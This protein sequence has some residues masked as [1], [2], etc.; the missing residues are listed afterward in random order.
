MTTVAIAGIAVIRTAK[1]IGLVLTVVVAPATID[2]TSHLTR[3]ALW[4]RVLLDP[5]LVVRVAIAGV[6][7]V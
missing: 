4:R 6:A 7:I 3:R 1:I 5:P 2:V